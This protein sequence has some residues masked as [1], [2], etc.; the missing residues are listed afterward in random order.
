MT[1][2]ADSGADLALV[3]LNVRFWEQ[4][5][6]SGRPRTGQ[7]FRF[8]NRKVAP[9]ADACGEH[10]ERL[11]LGRKPTARFSGKL[12]EISHSDSRR[13]SDGQPAGQE[14]EGRLSEAHVKS[15][16]LSCT[17]PFGLCRTPAKLSHSGSFLR[18][19]GGGV[20]P[21]GFGAQSEYAATWTAVL[22]AV[23]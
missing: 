13:F 4:I 2:P 23:S 9:I 3:A 10:V 1:Q 16:R 15:G 5:L 17:R 6:G 21:I 19:L 20:R 7:T 14:A 8:L 18:I 11:E 22:G 12:A